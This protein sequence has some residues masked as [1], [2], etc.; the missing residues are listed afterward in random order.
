MKKVFQ[1]L[2]PKSS[3][4]SISSGTRGLPAK[5]TNTLEQRVAEALTDKGA[6][7]LALAWLVAEIE[8][9]IRK[10]VQ[11]GSLS[12]LHKLPK[13]R[14][15]N[16]NRLNQVELRAKEAKRITGNVL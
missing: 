1:N 6:T 5:I 2:S 14:V 16:I 15:D 13:L 4:A 11:A 10:P 8:A 3:T 12:R 7:S 9:A